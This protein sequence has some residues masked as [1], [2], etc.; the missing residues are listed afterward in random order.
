MDS[1]SLRYVNKKKVLHYIQNNQ[2]QSRSDISKA[3]QISKPTIS[4]IVDELLEEKWIR[5]KESEN[6]SSVGGRKP[7]HIYFNQN[8]YYLIGV[9]IGGT[10]VELAIMNLA[11]DIKQKAS[12]STQTNVDHLIEAIVNETKRLIENSKLSSDEIFGM[13]VGVPGITDVEKGIVI[14]A[15]SIR[16]KN[17]SLKAQLEEHLPFPVY[18]DNDVNVAVL[19]E[20]WKGHG[21][22]SKNIL[23]I[24]LGTGIGC[25]I[26][27]NG[28]L[29]RGSSF[30]AGEIGYMVT[31]KK[32]AEANYVHSFDGYGFLDS[33]VGGPAISREMQT[34]LDASGKDTS[35]TAKKVFQEAISGDETAIE[36]VNESLSH[37]A[38]ALINVISIINPEKIILGGGI[39][40]SIHYFLPNLR[41]IIKRHIP[42]HSD[43]VLTSLENV[44][45]IGAGYL[46][47]KEYDSILKE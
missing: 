32:S 10:S 33:H 26:I 42:I 21:T 15:P 34:K 38:F 24:T 19:G 1:R 11:G 5:E 12:F 40:K 31:D 2:G 47:L 37:L 39:S 3:L 13:G 22:T 25:G 4:T 7:F 17:V 45:L 41:S 16:W 20:Q 6:A 27:L 36:T 18:I 14:D 29:Y 43:I 44:S 35:W 30:A 23:M 8:A 9:D 28:S 46:L